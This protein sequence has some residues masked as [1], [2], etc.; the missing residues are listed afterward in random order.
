MRKIVK[1]QCF[2]RQTSQCSSYLLSSSWNFC[3]VEPLANFQQWPPDHLTSCVSAD[4]AVA[5]RMSSVS[6]HNSLAIWLCLASPSLSHTQ[7]WG[8]SPGEPPFFSDR[9]NHKWECH[10][11]AFL[12]RARRCSLSPSPLMSSRH[13]SSSHC[14]LEPHH[15]TPRRC[16]WW[17][18]HR[19]L[20]T[21]ETSLAAR[22]LC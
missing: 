14:A 5:V 21:D 22:T 11:T 9:R 4:S 20:S 10:S 6:H 1:L 3:S 8:R 2:T 15:S 12:R 19:E 7:G 17:T 13:S 16:S 18:P